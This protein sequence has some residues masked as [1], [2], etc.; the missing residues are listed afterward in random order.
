MDKNLQ[1]R[2][3]LTAKA[4]IGETVWAKDKDRVANRNSKVHFKNGEWKC[5][6]F[7]YEVLKAA[8]CDIGTPNRYPNFSQ[9][10]MVGVSIYLFSFSR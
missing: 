6:L 10:I 9:N 2:I 4:N 3:Y 8:G 5:N 1:E 7:V